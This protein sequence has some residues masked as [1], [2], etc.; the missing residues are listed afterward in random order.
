MLHLLFVKSVFILYKF[1]VFVHKYFP[2]FGFCHVLC[3]QISFNSIKVVAFRKCRKF[4]ETLIIMIILILLQIK[5][6][7]KQ[8]ST[9]Q[10]KEEYK[11]NSIAQLHNC[12]NKFNGEYCYFRESSELLVIHEQQ[13]CI[14]SLKN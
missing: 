14:N 6:N 7:K 11:I 3:I 12:F 1:T 2:Y 4:S 10:Y 13:N 5:K 8:I 9:F